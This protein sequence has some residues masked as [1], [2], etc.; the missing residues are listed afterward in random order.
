MT[1]RVIAQLVGGP[2]REHRLSSRTTRRV[3]L[4]TAVVLVAFLAICQL[5]LPSIATDRIRD[6]LSANGSGVHVSISAFPAVKLL[7][8][9]A[10]SVVVRIDELHVAHRGRGGLHQL[11]DRASHADR[12]EASVGILWSH[13]LELRDLTLVKRGAEL[14]LGAEVTRQAVQRALPS[15]LHLVGAPQPGGGLNLSV[16]AR[17]LGKELTAHAEVL[18]RDGV[19]EV[20]PALPLLDG[21]GLTLFSDPRVTVESLSIVVVGDRYRLAAKGRYR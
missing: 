4:G 18:A 21:L 20:T 2:V 5:L 10:D 15:F 12:L 13:G 19:V 17:L 8:G 11:L 7:V 9:R 14:T 16:R 3:A 6:S 1:A